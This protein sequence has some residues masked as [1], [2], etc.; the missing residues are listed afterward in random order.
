MTAL[1]TWLV[2]VAVQKRQKVA[3]W[4]VSVVV[5]VD[6]GSPERCKFRFGTY[7]TGTGSRQATRG[8]WTTCGA[9]S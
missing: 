5:V 6:M 3:A 9:T 8:G 1:P 7:D 2:V 4:C